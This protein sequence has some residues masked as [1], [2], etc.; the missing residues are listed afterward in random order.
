MASARLSCGL[1]ETQSWPRQDSV[2]ALA[3]LIRD[4]GE[5]QSWPRRDAFVTLARL[6]PDLGKTPSRWECKSFA[7]HIICGYWFT[8]RN[9]TYFFF[10]ETKLCICYVRICGSFKSAK[11]NWVDRSQIAKS[12]WSANPQNAAFAEGPQISQKILV[13]K[14]A[15]LQFAKLIGGPPTFV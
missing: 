15:D 13:R 12:I 9:F 1:G 2:V 10:Q 5:I 11:N 3:R 14:F 4:L 7:K 6:T 8:K